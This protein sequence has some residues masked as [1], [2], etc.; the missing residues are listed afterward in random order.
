MVGRDYELEGAVA[1]RGGAVTSVRSQVSMANPVGHMSPSKFV[2]GTSS[3]GAK[4]S[5]GP[6]WNGLYRIKAK[7]QL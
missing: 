1:A 5:A 4:A 2:M 3:S 7:K 6:G